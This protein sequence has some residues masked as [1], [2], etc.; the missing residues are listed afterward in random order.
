MDH[1]H[2]LMITIALYDLTQPDMPPRNMLTWRTP[3]MELD[4][5]RELLAKLTNFLHENTPMPPGY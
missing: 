5:C 4:V 3:P 1:D 2:C